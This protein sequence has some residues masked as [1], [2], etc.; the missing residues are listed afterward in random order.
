M[1]LT[2]PVSDAE[3]YL[4]LRRVADAFVTEY[5]SSVHR[6]YLVLR[7]P[8]FR[9]LYDRLWEPIGPQQHTHVEE[10]LEV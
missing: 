4:P 8:T 2:L 7:Q 1:S 3:G 5:F 6:T 9:R 10:E